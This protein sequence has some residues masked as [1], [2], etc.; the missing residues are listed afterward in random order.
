M[1]TNTLMLY[2][3]IISSS[4]A[5]WES[6]LL[7]EIKNE[8]NSRITIGKFWRILGLSLGVLC[9]GYIVMTWNSTAIWDSI[10]A[11]QLDAA[12]SQPTFSGLNNNPAQLP[13]DQIA[14]IKLD[15]WNSVPSGDG[16]TIFIHIY[17]GSDYS[18]SSVDL[19]FQRPDGTDRIFRCYML[20]S[21]TGKQSLSATLGPRN[22]AVFFASL[23]IFAA[24][25]TTAKAD[26]DNAY[27]WKN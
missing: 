5:R 10:P 11:V 20:D 13:A 1:L 19:W 9:L 7:L 17:N 4:L 6:W 15:N 16:Q 12:I 2:P 23:G 22:S 26:I 3:F 24:Q 8:K 21:S 18:I 27:G 14:K 25:G